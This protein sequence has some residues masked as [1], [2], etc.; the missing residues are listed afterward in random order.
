M[1]EDSV[2]ESNGIVPSIL[3]DDMISCYKRV[4]DEIDKHQCLKLWMTV[5]PK[6]L[7]DISAE[8][9][10]RRFLRDFRPASVLMEQFILVFELN[11]KDQIHFH[12][13]C[14]FNGL[15]SK[16]TFTK[17]YINKWYHHNII[18]PIWGKAP[19]QG[20]MYLIKQFDY[21]YHFLDKYPPLI[22]KATIDDYR[23]AFDVFSDSD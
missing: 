4:Y 7:E 11:E 19:K 15:R 6:P 16:I 18:K 22:T 5:S 20:F 2:R 23:D 13:F 10:I 8:D 9:H 1:L 17:K 14:C 3:T 21:M 12:F